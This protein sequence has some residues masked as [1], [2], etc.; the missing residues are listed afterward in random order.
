MKVIVQENWTFIEAVDA[1]Y[2]AYYGGG[3]ISKSYR[4]IVI[5]SWGNL[6]GRNIAV[7]ELNAFIAQCGSKKNAAKCLDISLTSLTQIEKFFHALPIVEKR[8]EPISPQMVINQVLATEESRTCEF[9]E[10][11]G[12]NSIKAIANTVDEYAVAFLN[13]GGGKIIWGIQNV[14]GIIK[15]V[16]LTKDER[17]E[18]RRAV[19]QK[20]F[21]IQPS[22]DPT[23][24]RLNLREVYSEG[25]EAIEDICVIE[26]EVP[27]SQ[28]KTLYFT[29]G[30]EAFVRVDGVKKK[31]NGPEIQDWILR[32]ERGK[33]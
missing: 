7:Q 11:F 8:E 3:L 12:K 14:S 27:Y 30:N 23:S 1:A 22:I 31:L 13:S 4:N 9:K 18:L 19:S 15:G 33:D 28:N 16:R 10:V 32:R 20:L 24:Y 25:G 26:V 2:K 5:K 29:A 17:D 21:G 6:V